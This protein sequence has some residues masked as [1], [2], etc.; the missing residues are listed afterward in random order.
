MSKPIAWDPIYRQRAFDADIIQHCVRW[1]VTQ[2]LSY[3]DLV[4]IMAERG[5]KVA[6]STI[7]RWVARYMPEFQ[8]R[9]QRFGKTVGT[10]WRV[11]EEPD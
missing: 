4:E 9:R 1:Y 10:S 3:W 6:H 2:R 8:K 7:L 11:D 5:V